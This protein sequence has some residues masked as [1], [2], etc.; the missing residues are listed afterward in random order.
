MSL[1]RDEFERIKY[2][3]EARVLAEKD[4]KKDNKNHQALTRWGGAL[5]ELAHLTSGNDAFTKMEQAVEKFNMALEL[6]PNRHDV[7]W[8]LGNAYTSQGFLTVETDAAHELFSKATECFTKALKE[9]PHSETYAKA[10]DMASKAPAL[11]AELQKQLANSP[12]AFGEPVGG[13]GASKS[14]DFWYDMA[15]WVI[16]VGLGVGIAALVRNSPTP[17]LAPS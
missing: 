8:C 16:L 15:G 9:E 14:A 5:L 11:H 2:F 12:T 1:S 4:Y 6:V 10:L 7:L 17:N 3:E 13:S